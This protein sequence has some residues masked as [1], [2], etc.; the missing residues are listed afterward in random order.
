MDLPD[1]IQD[2]GQ[3]QK[4]GLAK[5]QKC[6]GQRLDQKYEEVKSYKQ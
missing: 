3:R 2:F 6:L 4:K 5:G 1:I